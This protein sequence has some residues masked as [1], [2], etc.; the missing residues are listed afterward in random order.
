MIDTIII[1][2]KA[3]CPYCEHA[4]RFFESRNLPYQEIRIDLD[5]QEREIMMQRSGRHTVPQIFINDVSIGG[6]DDMMERVKN[7]TFE[8]LFRSKQ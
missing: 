2:T 5:S 7:K 4:K 6:Y 1:Y 3:S 8:T